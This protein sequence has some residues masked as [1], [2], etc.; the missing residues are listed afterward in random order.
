MA[1]KT[2]S[3][4][5]DTQHLYFFRSQT[6][7]E[8]DSFFL[9]KPDYWVFGDEQG[10]AYLVNSLRTQLRAKKT[11]DLERVPFT[12]SNSQ[13]VLILPAQDSPVKPRI[14]LVERC[15][16]RGSQFV[17][18]LILAGNRSGFEK[19]AQIVESLVA[20]PFDERAFSEHLHVNDWTDRWV[21]RESVS[22]NIRAPVS[23]WSDK[24]A[25]ENH[26]F[27][28]DPDHLNLPE[29]CGYLTPETCPYEPPDVADAAFKLTDS[30]RWS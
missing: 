9:S 2:K 13:P 15:A 10:F 30:A 23:R 7:W 28:F 5:A 8:S 11:L 18:E 24:M 25:R 19:L 14:R 29:E 17:M 1:R 4:S 27:L 12:T 21:V 26:S 6:S 16:F 22:L 3:G 20:T